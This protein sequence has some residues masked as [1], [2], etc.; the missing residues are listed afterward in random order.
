MSTASKTITV[1][2]KLKATLGKYRPE[3]AESNPFAVELPRGS[4]VADLIERLGVP[5]RMAKLVFVDHTQLG[6]DAV[7]PDG[8][9]VEMFPPIAGG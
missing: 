6:R 3:W 9:A 2:V 5:S 1:S 7:L 8:A 4:S